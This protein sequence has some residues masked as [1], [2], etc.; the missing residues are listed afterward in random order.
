MLLAEVYHSILHL[1]IWL[2]FFEETT[3][4]TCEYDNFRTDQFFNALCGEPLGREGSQTR[5][6]CPNGSNGKAR[7]F[8]AG[9]GGKWHCKHA[10]CAKESACPLSGGGPRQF[11]LMARPELSDRE[12]FELLN[13]YGRTPDGTKAPAAKHQEKPA[14]TGKKTWKSL[15]DIRAWLTS[16]PP[17]G[18]GYK[19]V[20]V[21]EYPRADG[22]ECLTVFRCEPGKDKPKDFYQ[23][24]KEPGGWIAG[25]ISSNVPLYRLTV[26][27]A[28]ESALPVIVCEGEKKADALH[29]ALP[30]MSYWVTSPS[31]G[32]QSPEK[33]D[34]KPVNGRPVVILPDN[35]E[36]GATFAQKVAALSIKAGA[37]S[38][39]IAEPFYGKDPNDSRDVGDYLSE[40]GAVAAI[41]EAIK[42]ARPVGSTPGKK[43]STQEQPQH[44]KP[45]KHTLKTV[46]A[47]DLM[48]MEFEPIRWVVPNILAEGYA[49]LA[50][51]PKRGKSWFALGLSLAVASG[52]YALGKIKVEPGDVLYLALEDTPRR[53]QNRLSK[54]AESGKPLPSRLHLLTEIPPLRDGGAEALNTWLKDH[55]ETRLVVIDTVNHPKFVPPRGKGSDVFQED[56]KFG[57]W[58]QKLAHDHQMCVMGLN[59]T[60]KSEVTYAV[61]AVSGSTGI[62]APADTILVIDSAIKGKASAVLHVTGRDVPAQELAMNFENSAWALMGEAEEFACTDQRKQVIDLLRTHGPLAS[63][64][65]SDRLKSNYGALRKLLYEMR[66]AGLVT[67]EGGERSRYTLPKRNQETLPLP[68]EGNVTGNVKDPDQKQV[69]QRYVTTLPTLPVT[70]D[71]DEG[72]IL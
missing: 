50:G 31:Q 16:A 17:N 6:R 39:A 36:P 25:G 14:T 72:E 20:I 35:D 48:G 45:T 53:L 21:S 52:G 5:Y 11:L 65:I 3:M 69:S 7:D 63:K 60:K 18:R 49:L 8:Y 41:I 37:A 38:V 68:H 54:L 26:I 66:K 42:K 71:P 46:S 44:M 56:Y 9:S 22:S 34:W 70:S 24:R 33:S 43:A 62:T 57:A 58:L 23:Y 2:P 1:V 59:H 12:A 67:Q 19:T 28:K 29:K 47:H 51:R 61:D 13:Q 27:S 10:K 15:A 32:A 40:A 4:K 64:E 55:P 30:F